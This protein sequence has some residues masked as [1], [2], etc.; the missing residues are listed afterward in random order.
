MKLRNTTAIFLIMFFGLFSPLQAKTEIVKRYAIVVAANNGGVNRVPLQY[1]KTD[2]ESLVRV[3]QELGGLKPQDQLMLIEPSPGEV[4]AALNKLQQQIDREK[5]NVKR[6]ELFFYYSGHSDE[7]GLLLGEKQLKY[8]ELKAALTK[9]NSDV[10]IAILDSCASGAFTRVKGG[11]HKPPFMQD[12]SSNVKG[13]AIM[14]SSSASENA[15]ESD[16][17][18][19]SYF[20]HYFV[21]ALRGAADTTLDKKIT[22][23]EAY[24]YAFHE[25]LSRTEQTL[26]GAQHA[27][28]DFKL[29][30]AG[31]LVL[32]ELNNAA[33]LIAI[34]KPLSGRFYVRDTNGRL[35]VEINKLLD[36]EMEVSLPPQKYQI[37]FDSQGTL[38]RTSL[39]VKRGK[40]NKLGLDQFQR[41]TPEFTIARGSQSTNNFYELEKKSPIKDVVKSKLNEKLDEF[42]SVEEIPFRLSISPGISY[43]KLNKE[44]K[45]K[46]VSLDIQ[47]LGGDTDVAKVSLGVLVSS[48]KQ[49]IIGGQGS[50]VASMAGGDVYGGQGAGIASF[51]EGNIYGGQGAG[52]FASNNGYL[53]GGKGATILVHTKGFIKG[54][55]GS[56]VAAIANDDLSGGQLAG[57][58][59]IV[60]GNVKGGH[61]AGLVAFSGG[62][63]EGVQAA[64]VVNILLGN[65]TGI[66]V[67]GI[68]NYA[69]GD[70][71]GTQ[72]SSVVNISGG[73]NTGAQ[74]GMVNISQRAES[75]QLGLVNIA[76]KSEGTAFG[77]INL[78]GNGRLDV[79][80]EYDE[81]FYRSLVV[82]SGSG[83]WFNY[84]SGGEKTKDNIQKIKMKWGV[85]VKQ[86]ISDK[87]DVNY[88]A[89]LSVRFEEDDWEGTCSRCSH[90]SPIISVGSVVSYAIVPRLNLNAG[91]SFNAIRIHP[92][93]SS[94]KDEAFGRTIGDSWVGGII[95]VQF[96]LL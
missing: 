69:Q 87:F 78:I 20:T 1:A 38:Y 81:S 84:F 79:G 6:S 75:L 88:E 37:T 9:M 34:D 33:A 49:D 22:L 30:G 32:T 3:L 93:D 66:Q 68:S 12:E 60:N 35:L 91:I 8:A 40:K 57:I 59:S 52:V 85:G 65:V 17:I 24:Q 62:D 39:F 16:A 72:V 7:K 4:L 29:A 94:E 80:Y 83:R 48:V 45:K 92:R 5:E 63:V 19:G 15:Q 61:G 67:A 28:Y 90:Y 26:N 82:R 2:A 58:T 56:I 74:V 50:T 77:I 42:N 21:S 36:V 18:G 13:Y 44:T 14:T 73:K 31:D 25:T 43:P 53:F 86:P 51:V 70:V 89:T 95:G 11:R 76:K 27:A 55:Q 41:I 10:E 23:N 47:T 96:S 46:H 64:G 54:G 71:V